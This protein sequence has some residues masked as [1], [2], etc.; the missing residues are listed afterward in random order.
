MITTEEPRLR[1]HAAAEPTPLATIGVIIEGG[2]VVDVRSNVPNV[3]IIIADHDV[4]ED[5]AG[6]ESTGSVCN[7]DEDPTDRERHAVARANS[8]DAQS[9]PHSIMWVEDAL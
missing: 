5:C 8:A 3:Q 4:F 1:Q 2:L 9:L 6:S 7:P